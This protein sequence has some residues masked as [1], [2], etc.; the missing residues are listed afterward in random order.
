MYVRTEY[1]IYIIISYLTL[2]ILLSKVNLQ[3]IIIINVHNNHKI[4]FQVVRN[5]VLFN[6]T[7]FCHICFSVFSIWPLNCF[8]HTAEITLRIID[9]L[10]TL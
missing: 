10:L 1:H 7:L 8:L 3:I 5:V 2:Y 9:Y 4:L 6:W